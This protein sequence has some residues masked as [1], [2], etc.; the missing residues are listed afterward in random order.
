M[1]NQVKELLGIEAELSED[2]KLAQMKLENGTVLE[3]EKFEN[4]QPVFIVTEDEKVA[5]P[6]G[7]YKLEDG[8][9]LIVEEE[10]VIKEIVD[11]VKEEEKEEEEKEEVK[12]S[13]EISENNV[14][15]ETELEDEK[16]E[17]KY[18]TKQ[19]LNAAVDEI[20]AMID[21]L[22]Y[23]K[24]EDMSSEVAEEL[25]LAMTEMLSKEEPVELSEETE[26][27]THS[28]EGKES[29]PL[30]LY[31]KKRTSTTKDRVLNRILNI[32]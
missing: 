18:V 3:A 10:G 25:G 16:E 32:K 6:L 26:K 22:K 19:E 20:K 12:A 15:T 28:P 27:V 5:L 13:E 23:D 1:L 31:A 4:E 7:E 24:K 8:K 2:I 29:K 11:E 9:V 17:M 30:N 21:E 14:E